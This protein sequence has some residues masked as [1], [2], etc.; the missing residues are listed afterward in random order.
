MSRNTINFILDSVLLV[1]F[2]AL[3]W[4][5]IVLHSLFPAGTLAAGWTIWG[6]GF[7][8][9]C[10][11]QFISLLVFSVCVGL[12]LILHWPWV[13]GFIAARLSKILGRHVTTNESTRTVYGVTTMIAILSVLGVLLLL[14]Q[15]GT[16]SP[17]S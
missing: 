10:E 9:W 5:S 7:D 11:I 2:L 3:L 6:M 12:H 4:T 8:K 16:Q 17:K 14:A 15:F 13:C 1:A